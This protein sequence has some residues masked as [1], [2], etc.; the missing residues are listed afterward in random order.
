MNWPDRTG[1]L[2]LLILKPKKPK[3]RDSVAD[4]NINLSPLQLTRLSE[5]DALVASAAGLPPN[6]N[7][8]L[9]CEGTVLKRVTHPSVTP[10]HVTTAMGAWSPAALKNA[11][12]D[13]R[14]ALVTARTG[15]NNLDTSGI[16][17]VA[18]AKAY[19]DLQKVVLQNLATAIRDLALILYSDNRQV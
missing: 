15:I 12:Q 4:L 14:D 16:T 7:V 17:N 3:E 1:C 11:F 19:L 6:T 18:T 13:V 9:G 2:S 10:Q 5:L 8:G